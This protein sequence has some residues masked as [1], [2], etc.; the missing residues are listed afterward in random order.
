MGETI[1]VRPD[2]MFDIARMEAFLRERIPLGEGPLTVEQFPT[3][4]SNLTYLLKAGEWEAVMRR[5][6]LG[7]LPPKAHDMERE[8]RFLTL[9]SEVFPKAPR[10]Y[11]CVGENPIIDR[12]F[13]VMERRRGRVLDRK[14]P[15]DLERT[16]EFCR[17]VTQAA[18]NALAELH[19]VDWESAGL[20]QIS[21]P[22]G[23]MERQ[24]TG[25]LGRWERAKTE[26][27]AE[28]AELVKILVEGRPPSPPATVIHNDYKLNN[29]MLD[30]AD[31]GRVTAILDWEMS[32]IGDPLADLAAFLS[33]WTEPEDAGNSLGLS[34]VTSLP[35]FPRRKDVLEMYVRQSGRDIST[36]N[37][38]LVFSTFKIAVIVQQIFFRWKNGQTRDDRFAHHGEIA[39]GL[40]QHAIWLSH[41]PMI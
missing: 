41:N 8:C 10:P 27:L 28:M 5:P 13:F 15:A 2:E 19:Q 6:P 12:P 3:G 16:P 26:E 17:T 21:K 35:E 23:F 18:V 14:W 1:P 4:H 37:W 33:Y 7:P 25:W 29:V 20:G 9:L 34:S 36:L 32:T 22:E 39:K 11:L 40:I 31:F 38:Y 30:P 24:V